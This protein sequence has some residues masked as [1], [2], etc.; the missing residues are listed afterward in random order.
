MRSLYKTGN[1]PMSQKTIENIA[2]YTTNKSIDGERLDAAHPRNDSDSSIHKSTT[3]KPNYNP[4][5]QLRCHLS[6][7]AA[8]SALSS[9]CHLA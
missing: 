6:K 5:L 7:Y 8:I 4:T 3:I 1:R 9:E 2:P